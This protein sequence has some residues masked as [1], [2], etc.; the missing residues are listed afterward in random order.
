MQALTANSSTR[1]FARPCRQFEPLVEYA[2]RRKE[3]KRGKSYLGQ[4]SSMPTVTKLQKR[5]PQWAGS[6]RRCIANNAHPLEASA[7]LV[8]TF[9]TSLCALRSSNDPDL[10]ASCAFGVCGAC[11]PGSNRHFPMRRSLLFNGQCAAFS[12][13]AVRC[14]GRRL[15]CPPPIRRSDDSTT[16]KR[17]NGS[18]TS[19][20]CRA[21]RSAALCAPSPR[22]PHAR[23]AVADATSSH[24]PRGSS[25][26]A[27][28]GPSR[29]DSFDSR[30]EP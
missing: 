4:L 5:T 22:H 27:S 23:S 30:I 18:A 9:C 24:E 20:V 7:R 29:F 25:L 3:Y 2:A 11:A 6:A 1:L 16:A 17:A 10:R 8:S 28:L 12:R 14:G 21:C 26:E 13:G 15:R 19:R